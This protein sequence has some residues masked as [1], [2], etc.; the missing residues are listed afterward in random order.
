MTNERKRPGV[1]AGRIAVAALAA[2]GVSVSSVVITA[3]Q[4]A[5][6][7]ATSVVVSTTKNAKLGTILVSGKTLYFIKIAKGTCGTACLKIWPALMLPKG[8]KKAIAGSGVSASKLGTVARSGGLLQVTYAGKPLYHFTGDTA[9]GQVRGNVK[10][11]WGTWS[12]V[13]TVKPVA[14]S[15]GGTVGGGNTG[16]GGVAF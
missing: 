8:V 4:A 16:T 14:V 2:G 9:I 7:H 6:P 5:T 11:T 13:V 12:D 15:G 3:A 1:A 10:D